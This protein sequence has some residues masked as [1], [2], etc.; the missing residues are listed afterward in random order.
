[1]SEA[2]I[3]PEILQWARERAKLSIFE[4]ST[5]ISQSVE[6]IELWEQGKNKPT[7]I[8]A[9]NLAHTLHIPF[10]YFFLNKPPTEESIVP[11]LR[12]I[13]D[14]GIKYFSLEL[15]DV[16][17]D[18]L[19]KQD[20]YKDFLKDN[21]ND[22]L[23]FI[24]R[25]NINTPTNEIVKDITETLGLTVM[26]RNNATNWEDFLKI[27]I[28]K[29]EES[30]IW[31]MRNSKVG[32]NT[33]RILNVVEFR[34]FAL[35]ENYAPLVFIN[36]ADAK[37]AQIFTLMHEIAH[38][39]LGESGISDV[40]ITTEKSHLDN[41]IEKKCNEIAAELLVPKTNLLER[42]IDKDLFNN[43]SIN[44]NFFKV[45]KIVIARRALDLE[46]ITK[47]DFYSYYEKQKDKWI[48]QK[49]K[50]K[51]SPG[52][53]SFYKLLPITNGKKFTEA[54]L[55]S[56]LTQQ[57]LTRYGARLLGLKPDKIDKAATEVGFI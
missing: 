47:N 32:N 52:G 12:T 36:S 53:P 20:W 25:F 42:W 4:L 55:L 57:T 17:N 6:K 5:K 14:E 34:G 37:A 28:N 3:T 9:Q 29:A 1:M 51:L 49:E 33:R 11:D 22:E 56:V 18:S 35:C 7:F 54:V 19:R 40:G 38:L 23:P 26:D 24:G 43:I 45:S 15:K 10:G 39:W 44:S 2:L 8:Q 31:V 46:L 27:L 41:K 48:K 30:G 50:Q 16:I 21:G 13:K